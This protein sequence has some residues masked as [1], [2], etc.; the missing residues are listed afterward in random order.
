[1][2]SDASNGFELSVERGIAATPDRVWRIMTERLAEWWC[3]KPWRTEIRA[4][5]WRSGGDFHTL[6]L[7]P[8][9]GDESEVAGVLLEVVPGRRF[10]FTDALTADWVPR[11]PFMVGCFEVASDG[12]G[13]RLRA[14]SRHWDE[15]AMRQH[16]EMGFHEGWRVVADQLAEL[17]EQTA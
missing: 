10:V 13:T 12:T 14:W 16:A 7:G 1:M 5:E 15:G 17:A 4:L 11:T 8:N 3:P 6:M 2:R 9:A